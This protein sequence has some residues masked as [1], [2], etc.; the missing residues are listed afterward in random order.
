MRRDIYR[1]F[2]LPLALDSR[3]YRISRDFL[4]SPVSGTR[5][6][7]FPLSLLVLSL[8]SLASHPDGRADITLSRRCYLDAIF[9]ST[10]QF[11]LQS[12]IGRGTRSA[13]G[14]YGRRL[15]ESLSTSRAFSTFRRISMIFTRNRPEEISLAPLYRSSLR[16]IA[17]RSVS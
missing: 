11:Y 2:R 13:S 1:T 8:A 14:Q 17:N 16:G 10:P 7:L 3:F 5:E 9:L 4:P 6:R 15:F 12:P